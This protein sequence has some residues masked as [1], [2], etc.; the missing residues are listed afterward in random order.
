MHKTEGLK[1]SE[2]SFKTFLSKNVFYKNTNKRYFFDQHLN[3]NEISIKFKSYLSTQEAFGNILNEIGKIKNS[4]LK[5]IIT[6]SPDVTVSTSLGS[7]VNQ[8]DIFSRNPKV[9]FLK[10]KMCLPHRNGNIPQRTTYRIRN[11]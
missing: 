7:W 4:N 1:I 2:E 11:C 10:K 9:I 6:T 8:R 3:I 5:R